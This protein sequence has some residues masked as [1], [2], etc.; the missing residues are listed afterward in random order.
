MNA[1]ATVNSAARGVPGREHGKRTQ[2]VW[3]ALALGAAL[4]GPPLGGA[5]ARPVVTPSVPPDLQIEKFEVKA[6]VNGFWH[7]KATLRNGG[8]NPHLLMR[9]YPGGGKLRLKQSTGGTTPNPAPFQMPTYPDSPKLLAEKT[10]PAL[11]RGQA[12]TLEVLTKKRALFIAVAEP[13]GGGP[14]PSILPEVNKENNILRVNALLTKHFMISAPELQQFLGD[15]TG[16]FQIHLNSNDSFVRLPGFY[17]SHWNIADAIAEV[18]RLETRAH[19][20]MTDVNYRNAGISL[21]NEGRLMLTLHFETNNAEI[22]GFPE[23]GANGAVPD[24]NA[25]FVMATVEML[26]QYDAATQYFFCRG[27]SVAVGSSLDV[28]A[29][30]ADWVKTDFENKV[31]NAVFDLFSDEKVK[32]KISYELNRQIK[33]YFVPEGRI[34]DV[35]YKP[36]TIKLLTEYVQ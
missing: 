32:Q 29:P 17:E 30:A 18:P 23:L 28:L 12:I 11:A 22:D 9:T 15:L 14:N 7:L 8:N 21:G 16:Q 2:G 33:Q 26:L 6:P 36:G 31:K 19:W 27:P 3:A 25:S 1:F 4:A 10:I 13:A 20:A 35:Q 24:L 34:I 5:W